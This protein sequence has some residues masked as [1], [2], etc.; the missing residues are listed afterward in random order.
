MLLAE[1]PINNHRAVIDTGTPTSFDPQKSPAVPTNIVSATQNDEMS[2]LR[3]HTDSFQQTN[4]D[5]H[6]TSHF[7][8]SCDS[9][10]NLIDRLAKLPTEP[11]SLYIDLEGV[12][13]SR[14]GTIS[15]LQIFVS[16]TNCTYLIDVHTLREKAFLTLGT[17]GQTL[18][19]ILESNSIP[20]VPFD[21]R[22]DSDA[23]YAHFG[24]SLACIQDIQLMELATRTFSKRCVNGLSRC[25]ESDAA[26]TPSEKQIWK[27]TKE[28]GL[29]LFSPDKG[30]SYEVFNIRPLAEDI[31]AYC[32]QDVKFMPGLWANYSSK[33]TP[34][35]AG[36]V[37]KATE[38]R[39][40]LSHS[41]SFN[42]KGRHMALGP[43]S[44]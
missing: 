36:K 38:E 22:R 33:L 30:G 27:L 11:P 14:H 26:M 5:G 21:V 28:K 19:T 44:V 15:I 35:W 12:R 25:I 2:A 31:M 10:A 43:W 40:V 4:L 20:K 1:N 7:I 6:L 34:Q 3:E 8:D 37:D 17:N 29:R 32:I 18:K 42:T 13:L 16:L 41:E 24:I 9:L 23:L 39:V